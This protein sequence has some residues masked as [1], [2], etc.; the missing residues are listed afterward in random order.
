MRFYFHQE[1]MLYFSGTSGSAGKSQL[2]AFT[3]VQSGADPNLILIDFKAYKIGSVLSTSVIL[4]KICS[5]TASREGPQVIY[6]HTE[7]NPYEPW[8]VHKSTV[9]EPLLDLNIN[10]MREI[11]ELQAQQLTVRAHLHLSHYPEIRNIIFL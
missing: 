6:A 7:S 4:S 9:L 1:W 2:S 8:K 11:E 10:Q 3:G 5:W